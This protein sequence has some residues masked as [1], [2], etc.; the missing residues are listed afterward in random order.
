MVSA[1]ANEQK[2]STVS[3]ISI[4]GKILQWPVQIS[5]VETPRQ[6]QSRYGRGHAREICSLI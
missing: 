1:F 6:I 4:L 2:I 3:D 5:W